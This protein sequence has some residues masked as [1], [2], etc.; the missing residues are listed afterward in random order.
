MGALMLVI[1]SAFKTGLD[2]SGLTRTELKR[3]WGLVV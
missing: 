3:A 1:F 2:A